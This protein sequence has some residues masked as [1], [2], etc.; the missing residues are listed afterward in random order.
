MPV[1][2]RAGPTIRLKSSRDGH[3]PFTSD[4]LG[5]SAQAIYW[6]DVAPDWIHDADSE[7]N[8]AV[9]RLLTAQR[10]RAAF[11]CAHYHPEK[12]GAHLLYRLLSDVAK[13]GN[14]QSGHYQLE[15]YAIKQAFKHI[16]SSP[17]LTPDQ[18]AGLEF[19][20]LEVL[21]RPWDDGENSYGIPNLERYIEQHPEFYVQAIAWAYKRNDEGKDPPE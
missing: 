11:S 18:K 9:E 15:E 20:F 6:K 21:A 5:E 2:R 12:L 4:E 14:E 13:G 3:S 10:P 16:D 1:P 8:E 19:A 17:D 7:N